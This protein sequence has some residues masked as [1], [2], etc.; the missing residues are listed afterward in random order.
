MLETL[1]DVRREVRSS[2]E[3]RESLEQIRASAREYIADNLL[4]VRYAAFMHACSVGG[5][6]DVCLSR[7]DECD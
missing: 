1:D 7:I 6:V 3:L 5:S 4:T 2:T